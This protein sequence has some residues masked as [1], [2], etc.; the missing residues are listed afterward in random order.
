MSASQK[1]PKRERPLALHAEPEALSERDPMYSTAYQCASDSSEVAMIHRS[2]EGGNGPDGP[3]AWDPMC[4]V[5]FG[6][7]RDPF[8]HPN[9]EPA[10]MGNGWQNIRWS[11]INC[12]IEALLDARDAAVRTGMLPPRM[13]DEEYARK[14]D[15]VARTTGQPAV[16][17]NRGAQAARRINAGR[18]R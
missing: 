11:A 15:A 17:G 1:K 18:K 5:F 12:V 3:E 2:L 14:V 6:G 9:D 7:G 8:L 16:F 13:N 10:Q 4:D